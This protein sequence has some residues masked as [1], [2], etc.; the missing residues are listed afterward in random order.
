MF[1]SFFQWAIGIGV[2]IGAGMA[3][4]ATA[5][6]A[7]DTTTMRDSIRTLERVERETQRKVDSLNVELRLLDSLDSLRTV[8]LRGAAP[9]WPFVIAMPAIGYA[10]GT[11]DG[12][13]GGYRDSFRDV[14]KWA[15]A[16]T[17]AALY[18]GLR[19]LGVPRWAAF[20][21]PMLGGLALEAG[22]SRRGG[23]FSTKD[24]AANGAGCGLAW[25]VDAWIG[26]VRR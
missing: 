1:R 16:S 18:S 5:C 21:A 22:Q 3:I 15:H 14:D 24:L 2:T 6:G 26:R 23:F 12:D 9:S 25:A 8:L 10:V 19:S 20:A 11:L 4:A 7:Q 13:S 17:C